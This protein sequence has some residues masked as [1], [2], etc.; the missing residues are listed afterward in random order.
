MSGIIKQSV[1]IDCSKDSFHA[2]ICSL[3]VEQDFSLTSVQIF[4]NDKPGFDRFLSWAEKNLQHSITTCFIMEATGVYYESL[5]YRLH[6]E[7]KHVVVILVGAVALQRRILPLMY[8]IWKSGQEYDPN[9]WK[10]V[11]PEL[12]RDY[13]G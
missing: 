3:S 2:C 8:S 10:K 1:G 11:A 6:K 5:A 13:A 9:Y 12:A 7:E 4:S